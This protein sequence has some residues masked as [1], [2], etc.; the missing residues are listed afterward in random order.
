[1]AAQAGLE[2]G[3]IKGS[4]PHGRIVK[5]DI[6]GGTQGRRAPSVPLQAEARARTRASRSRLPRLLPRVRSRRAAYDEIPLNNMRKVI[7]RRLTEAKQTIP[8]FYL[9]LDCELD[10]LLALR[11]QLNGREGADYKLSVNDFVIKAVALAHAQGAGRER[12]LGRRQDLPVQGHRRLGRGRH[13]RR[14]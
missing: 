1:M 2:L 9:T 13:R 11:A 7:A 14:A 6:D 8:H 5:A 3:G 10:A 12:L 4:G